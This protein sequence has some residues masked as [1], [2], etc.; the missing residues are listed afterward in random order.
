LTR[1]LILPTKT[2]SATVAGEE[3][4]VTESANIGFSERNFDADSC[5]LDKYE[6]PVK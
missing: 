6:I 4:T 3:D 2:V 1:D 5:A